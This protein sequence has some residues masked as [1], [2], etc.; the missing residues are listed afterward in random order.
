MFL[1]VLSSLEAQIEHIFSFKHTQHT[2]I[3]ITQQKQEIE[4]IENRK[5]KCAKNFFV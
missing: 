5:K 3:H 1:C 2:Y 4:Q